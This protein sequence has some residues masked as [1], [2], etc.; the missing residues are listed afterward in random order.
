LR[1]FLKTEGITTDSGPRLEV[2]DAYDVTALRKFSEMI[3]GSTGGWS[4]VILDFTTGPRTE[5][6]IVS[7][8]RLPSAKIDSLIAGKI[9]VDDLSLTAISAEAESAR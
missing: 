7:V 8:A 3:T 5:L 9:W 6:V 2:Q 4:Q 1:G